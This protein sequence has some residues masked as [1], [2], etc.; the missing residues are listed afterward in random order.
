MYITLKCLA[1]VNYI[2]E[3]IEK[4]N[5]NK[6]G[7]EKIWISGKRLQK[8]LYFCEAEYMKRNNG[9]PLFDDQ[10]Y[11]WPS[12]PAIDGIYIFLESNHNMQMF[13]IHVPNEPILSD[14]IKLIIKHIL[15]L[16]KN[17]GT[18]ELV[19]LSKVPNGPYS[20]IFNEENKKYNQIVPKIETYLYYSEHEMFSNQNYLQDEHK[21]LTKIK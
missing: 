8:I 7:K 13:P 18:N 16:T 14:D 17:L 9:N 20:K 12:G 4:F 21:I 3:E 5:K 11:A 19:K 1:I 15:E 10:F 2:L 6:E